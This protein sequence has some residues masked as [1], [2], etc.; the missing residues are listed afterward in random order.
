MF[1]IKKKK[2]NRYLYLVPVE[3]NLAQYEVISQEE[4]ENRVDQNQL[5]EGAKLYKVDKE[6]VIRFEKIT[7]LE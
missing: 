1:S 7:Y 4:L 5:E 2:E 3:D 6:I